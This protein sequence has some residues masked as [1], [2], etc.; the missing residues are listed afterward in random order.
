MNRREILPTPLVENL[1]AVARSPL[2][3]GILPIGAIRVSEISVASFTADD[4]AGRS[5]PVRGAEHVEEPY[6][7]YYEVQEDGRL[8]N[9]AERQKY[10][11]AAQPLL[12]ADDVQWK[13][14][15][16]RISEDA[17]RDGTSRFGEG[18]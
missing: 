15:L 10:R 1:D 13:V 11:L 5:F 18:S 2:S 17:H 4:L 8:D 12:V 7:F 16:E 3:A 6:S 9:P 14:L